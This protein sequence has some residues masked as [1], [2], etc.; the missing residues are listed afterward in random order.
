[1]APELLG[2]ATPGSLGTGSTADIS[3]PAADMW[4][5]GIMTYRM[6]MGI[7]LFSTYWEMSQYCHN[8][9]VQFPHS[10][11]EDRNIS[12]DGCA[13]IQALLAPRFPL[14]PSSTAALAHRWI[15]PST[16]NVS[17]AV[18]VESDTE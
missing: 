3:Y 8:P 13:F 5:L 11:L 18:I 6:V 2:L 7:A 15:R 12:P 4:A 9:E 14:R 16:S 10:Q 17:A 1:M